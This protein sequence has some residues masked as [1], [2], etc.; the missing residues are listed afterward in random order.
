M[1]SNTRKL[2][3]ELLDFLFVRAVPLVVV[4]AQS[5]QRPEI[6]A[7]NAELKAT[8]FLSNIAFVMVEVHPVMPS[9]PLTQLK[10]RR[11]VNIFL[12]RFGLKVRV[13]G[14]LAANRPFD[15]VAYSSHVT[16]PLSRIPCAR[17]Q[18][19][20]RLTVCP[21]GAAFSLLLR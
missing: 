11:A 8:L 19:C 17:C 21:G 5:T 2:L 9:L 6:V 18:H 15:Y 16:Q 13:C 4:I 14:L 1:E 7:G 20:N 10:V 3:L 12:V